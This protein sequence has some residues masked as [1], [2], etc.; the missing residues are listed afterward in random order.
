MGY[1]ITDTP[2]NADLI[3]VNTCAIREHA[4]QK[5]LSIVGQYKHLKAKKPTLI[6]G[7]CGCMVTQE[8]RKDEIKHRYPY[9]DF[10][11]RTSSLHRFPQLLTDPPGEQLSRVGV[12]HVRVQQFLLLLHRSLCART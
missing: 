12:D 10:V 2:E 5:A 1:E 4:E 6:I 8:H 7:V 11:F 9:V 3:M